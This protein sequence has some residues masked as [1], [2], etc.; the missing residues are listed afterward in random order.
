[1]MMQIMQA[2]VTRVSVSTTGMPKHAV[3]QAM[4]TPGGIEGDKQRNLKH[5]GG[6]DR[7]VC[8]Y[9]EEHYQWLRNNDVKV[10]AGDL[11]ENITTQ[12]ID[13]DALQPGDRLRIGD[14]EIQITKVRAPCDQLKQWS[15][16]LPQLMVGRS[17]W[18]ARVN[19]A[20]IVLPGDAIEIIKPD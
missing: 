5:H 10:R 2:V 12:G 8:L 14:C 11:G 9:S 3:L 1:M 13:L 19:R 15:E 6:P 20:A 18:V 16:K 4:V 17:G 7:A